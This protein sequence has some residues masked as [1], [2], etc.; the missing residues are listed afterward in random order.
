MSLDIDQLSSAMF[1]DHLALFPDAVDAT[2]LNIDT[3][4]PFHNIPEQFIRA[5]VTGVVTALADGVIFDVG[6]GKDDTP[7]EA[8]AANFTLP[9]TPIAVATFIVTQEWT[10]DDA[11][12][13]A[14]LFIG[15]L[16][17]QV[18]KKGKLL[19]DD[20]QEMGTG[21]GIVQA[22][23]NPELAAALQAGLETSLV[24]AFTASGFFGEDDVPGAPVNSVLAEQLAVYAEAYAMGL[25]SI[26]ATI[27]YKGSGGGSNISGL[28]NKGS[29]L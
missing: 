12:D 6:S 10:G 17:R 2:R 4:V 26:A 11:P 1:R 28:T 8:R 16:L 5:L 19:M 27:T 24:E 29:I 25:S 13:V 7:G 14:D 23:S 20:H 21:T 3:G 15:E 9:L 22:A 18:E